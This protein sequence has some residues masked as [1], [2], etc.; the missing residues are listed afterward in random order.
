MRVNKNFQHDSRISPV[1]DY[2]DF[3]SFPNVVD[4]T[5]WVKCDTWNGEL[6]FVKNIKEIKEVFCKRA[7]N[8]CED[9]PFEV[10]EPWTK[11]S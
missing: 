4:W 9:C 1:I 8:I 2:W 7:H 3:V 10:Y 6:I 5:F 11:M